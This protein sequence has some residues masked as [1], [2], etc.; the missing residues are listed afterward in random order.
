MHIN[1]KVPSPSASDTCVIDSDFL[2]PP[3]PTSVLNIFI[4]SCTFRMNSSQSDNDEMEIHDLYLNW[5]IPNEPNVELNDLHFQIW[6]GLGPLSND[7][8]DI[9]EIVNVSSSFGKVLM[10]CT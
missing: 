7:I 2:A 4:V 10:I 6:L 9:H 5:S 1:W 3:P 8:Q